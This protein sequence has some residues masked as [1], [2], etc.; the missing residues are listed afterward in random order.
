M[1][2]ALCRARCNSFNPNLTC[3]Q[4]HMKIAKSVIY[5]KNIIFLPYLV[6]AA[7]IVDKLKTTQ[8]V[9]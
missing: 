9:A 6:H 2:S 1:F 4:K 3:Q 5:A 7:H 8:G